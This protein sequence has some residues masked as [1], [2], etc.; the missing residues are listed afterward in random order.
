MRIVDDYR[1]MGM[2]SRTGQMSVIHVYLFD[3]GDKVKAFDNGD[4]I[5]YDRSNREYAQDSPEYTAL[6]GGIFKPQEGQSEQK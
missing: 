3:T 2:N 6:I 5:A 4:T 1:V